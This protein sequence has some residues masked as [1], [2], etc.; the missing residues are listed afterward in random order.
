MPGSFAFRD[1]FG[2]DN[3]LSRT[4]LS[5][6]AGLGVDN[7]KLFSAQGGAFTF[8]DNAVNIVPIVL[9]AGQTL[10]LDV[11]YGFDNTVNSIDT[12]LWL[13]DS[14]GKLLASNDTS[15]IDSGSLTDKDARLDY[16]AAATDLVYIAVT[17]KEN[18]YVDGTFTFDGEGKDTGLFQLNVGIANLPAL[19]VGTEGND[20][21]SLLATEKLYHALGGEDWI[22]ANNVSTYI[23]GGDGDDGLTG[24]G[25]ADILFG[26]QGMDWLDGGLGNDILVGG[27]DDDGLIGN[28]GVD[29]LF[30]GSGYDYFY[31]GDNADYLWGEAGNDVLHGDAGPDAMY[32]GRGNDSFDAEA[33]NDIHNGGAGIADTFSAYYGA[34]A[35]TVDLEIAGPQ[36]TGYGLDTLIAIENVMGSNGLDD[37]I[38]GDAANNSLSGLNGNDTLWGRGGND[39]LNGGEGKDEIHGGTHN[40]SIYGGAGD[41]LLFGDAGTDYI[42][43]GAGADTL[44]G[45][46]GTDTF[47]Y[48]SEADSLPAEY[49]TILD[50]KQ[51]EFDRINLTSVY[52]GTLEFRGA[53]PFQ[54]T[55]GEVR[56]ID[57]GSYQR[58]LVNLDTDAAAEMLIRVDTP[59]PLVLGDFYL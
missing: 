19:T 21:V 35:L 22:Y 57:A 23:D 40:D 16:K 43:G 52:S 15:A 20:G 37:T 50:F 38:S 51:A 33:G 45:G 56:V 44:R 18:D 36:N 55:G 8:S 7:A 46:S 41:D 31:G 34:V 54:N 2:T 13:I 24:G 25:K 12:E 32:G 47:N 59:D 4:S 10:S 53:D 48:S 6:G 28:A 29:R 58:V 17:Q 49:D 30:G 9:Q 14:N 5:Q 27:E 11:D 42:A 39:T 1:F 3:L 26:G